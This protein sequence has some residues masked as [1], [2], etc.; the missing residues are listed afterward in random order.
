MLKK[1]HLKKLREYDK[2]NYSKIYIT[3]R[4]FMVKGNGVKLM[5]PTIKKRIEWLKKLLGGAT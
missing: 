2:T 4:L 5:R 3:I 1:N